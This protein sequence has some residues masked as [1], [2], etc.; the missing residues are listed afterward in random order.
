MVLTA[1]SGASFVYAAVAPLD[2]AA[3][4]SNRAER[5]NPSAVPELTPEQ[6]AAY[7]IVELVNAERSRLGL[8]IFHWH[9]QVAAAAQAHSADMA[10]NRRMQHAGSDGSNAGHRLHKAGFDYFTWGENIGAGFT[11]GEPLF[12]AWMNSPGHHRQMV[13]D[14][15]FIGVGAVASSDGTPYWTLVV[16]S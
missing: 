10:A 16:A 13:G 7:V 15:A 2:E 4:V 3:E 9:D 14:F 8:P 5:V 1:L 11:T 6:R 12:D